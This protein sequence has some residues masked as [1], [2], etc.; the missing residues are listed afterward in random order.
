MM[1]NYFIYFAMTFNIEEEKKEW[2]GRASK[3]G[4]LKSRKLIL[5]IN[6]SIPIEEVGV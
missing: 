2:V 3:K 6:Q 1:Y 5:K 4:S